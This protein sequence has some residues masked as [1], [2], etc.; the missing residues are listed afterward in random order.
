MGR[1]VLQ[2][3][4]KQLEYLCRSLQRSIKEVT[5]SYRINFAFQSPKISS[6]LLH[7]LKPKLPV[8]EKS[9]VVYKF[10]CACKQTYIG[11]TTR[12]LEVRIR[13]HNQPSRASEIFTHTN[14]CTQYQESLPNNLTAKQ[15][16]FFHHI[17]NHFTILHANLHNY[18]QRTVS[19]SLY[20]SILQP[21]IN[22]QYSSTK[23]HLF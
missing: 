16:S 15:S 5:P 20:I 7:K 1:F 21:E 13:E 3:S 2:Y 10:E 22:E 9:G 12:N 11:E 4:N 17:K 23:L 8:L 14:T 6:F 19:E 18:N